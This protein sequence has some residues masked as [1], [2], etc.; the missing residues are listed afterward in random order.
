LFLG[1]FTENPQFFPGVF[2]IALQR[3]GKL[4]TSGHFHE[5]L[6]GIYRTFSNQLVGR[7]TSLFCGKSNHGKEAKEKLL[8]SSRRG[9]KGLGTRTLNECF[10]TYFTVAFLT[11]ATILGRLHKA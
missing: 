5:F 11:M 9:G 2:Y 6:L 1:A 10:I 3:N 7:T 4:V 8:S